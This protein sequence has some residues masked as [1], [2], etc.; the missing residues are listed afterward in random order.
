MQT[1]CSA[2]FSAFMIITTMVFSTLA[3]LLLVVPYRLRYAVI[4]QYGALNIWMLDVL[5]G[6]K[7]TVEGRENIPQETGIILSKHQSTWETMGLQQIF[8][9]QTFVVKRELLKVPF[10]GWGLAA[11]KPIAIDRG[12]GHKAVQQIVTQGI[13]RLKQGIWIVIFPEGTRVHPGQKIRYKLGGAILAAKSGYPVIPVALDS[14]KYWPKKQFLKKPG[15][16]HVVIG[17]PIQTRDRNPD[18]ILADVEEWI[19]STMKRIDPQTS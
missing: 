10:F 17:P 7:Y 16:I 18:D 1:L 13:E 3:V 6:L 9:P 11:M 14:G 19:E 8:P 5:C 4:K 15:T 2:L 12:A